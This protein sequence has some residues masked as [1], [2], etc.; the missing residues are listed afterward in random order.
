MLFQS[1]TMFL[2]LGIINGMNRELPFT[3]GQ[4]NIE[5]AVKYAETTLWFTLLNIFGFIVIAISVLPFVKIPGNYIFPIF[6]ILIIGAVSF[7]TTYL[8]ATFRANAD[9][10]KLSYIQIL[11]ALL[12]VVSILLVIYVGFI[13][14]VLR[15]ILLVIAI[16]LLAHIYRPMKQVKPKLDKKIFMNLL[17]IGLPIFISSYIIGFIGTVPNLFLLK[18]GN[19]TLL[20]IYAPLMTIIS[21]V[22]VLP[23]SITTYLYPKMT[24]AFGKTNDRKALWRK[25]LYSHIGLMVL[26]IPVV[27][28]C[29]VA[30]PW[31]IDNLIP[32]YNETKSIL[33]VGVFIAL[34]MSYKFG[35]TTLITLKEWKLIIVYIFLFALLQIASPLFFLSYLPV[36]KAVVAGQ[37]VAA[38]GMVVVSLVTNYLATHNDRIEQL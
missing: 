12:K 32:K 24:Y 8:F 14:F 11:Q 1:Y 21:A 16:A 13:G 3:M 28:A 15:E 26:G 25:T 20:G 2:R 23:D 33:G 6:A 18:F 30:V 10:N 5:L 35:Y 22:A 9:F 7:Y 37:L 19:V 38:A 31:L 17:K 36:L 27:F 4:G 29:L 34:F